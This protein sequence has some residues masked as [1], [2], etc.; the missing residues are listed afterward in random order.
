MEISEIL[1]DGL[2]S[3]RSC[4]DAREL[5]DLRVQYLGRKG[6]LKSLQKRIG[7]LP[8]EKR[9]AM[10]REVNEACKAFG[11][12]LEICKVQ[13]HEELLRT[14][15][16]GDSVDITLPGVRTRVGQRHPISQTIEDL[17]SILVGLGFHYDDYPEVETEYYNFDALNT[18]G[19]HPA[20]DLHDSFYTKEGLVLRTHTTAFQVH[21]MRDQGGAPIR[22]F[23]SGR[24]YRCDALDMSHSPTFHQT[25]A[26]AVDKN[27]SF[28]DLKW[29]LYAMASELFAEDAQLRF[30]PS[31]FPF[32]T[33]SAEVDVS[34]VACS[35]QGCS[36]CKHSGWLEILGS[37]M[38]RPEVLR[39]GDIDPDLHNGFAFG[40]GVERIA[41]LRYGIN[42]IRQ[43]YVNDVAFLR[44]F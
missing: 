32:T 10:G 16:A 11:D 2:C 42:D 8:T 13:L 39:A 23:T 24:C 26:I 27:L 28:A 17:K 5:E 34:C 43:F 6:L 22:S 41:M 21:A 33:P 18:P 37:G 14:Q 40:I 36:V 9:K 15:L 35:G 30:R 3:I 4:G 25:D 19:W 44:Q 12:A 29:T 7:T 1:E 38:I 20:R 31:Y